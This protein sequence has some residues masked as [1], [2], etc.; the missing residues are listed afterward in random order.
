MEQARISLSSADLVDLARDPSNEVI[1]EHAQA[2]WDPLR[3][4][5]CV[6]AI[7]NACGCEDEF[8]VL[9][10]TAEI[11]EF[12]EAHPRLF[13]LAQSKDERV[14]K[15]I[16][17]MLCTKMEVNAGKLSH[18]EAA[19]MVLCGIRENGVVSGAATT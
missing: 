11:V 14:M 19:N 2:P 12:R 13:E 3:V 10:E 5:K 4:G 16:Q 8:R 1:I 6:R 17:M 7:S 18:E 9:V 15:F